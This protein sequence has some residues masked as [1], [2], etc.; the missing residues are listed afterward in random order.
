VNEDRQVSSIPL[1]KR[2][3]EA[4]VEGQLVAYCSSLGRR[5]ISRIY[6]RAM[7]SVA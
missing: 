6:W 1:K 7:N 5:R 3:L 2:L 4:V